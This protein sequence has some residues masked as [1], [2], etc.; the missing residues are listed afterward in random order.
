MIRFRW[1]RSHL[2]CD[3]RY[4]RGAT[5]ERNPANQHFLP[6]CDAP[7]NVDNGFRIVEHPAA[8]SGLRGIGYQPGTAERDVVPVPLPMGAEVGTS[9][10][11]AYF[12]WEQSG[13][14]RRHDATKDIALN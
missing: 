5:P 7:Q 1:R 8:H 3:R 12:D 14:I 4:F 2:T 9:R 13:L 10:N 6:V 11:A